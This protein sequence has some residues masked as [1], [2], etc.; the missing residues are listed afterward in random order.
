MGSI[1]REYPD[2]FLIIGGRL[3]VTGSDT[4][5]MEPIACR[6]SEQNYDIKT[7]ADISIDLSANGLNGLDIG[8]LIVSTDYYV[9]AIRSSRFV[10]PVGFMV[11]LNSTVP[12]LPEKYDRYRKVKT[13][14]TDSSGSIIETGLS[15]SIKGIVNYYADLP[16]TPADVL[17]IWIVRYGSGVYLINRKPGGLYRWDIGTTSW[18]FMAETT[19]F[20]SDA[21]FEIYN[22]ADNTKRIGFSA[23]PI[24]SGNQRF[25]IMPD[26]NVSLA[27]VNNNVRSIQALK[28]PTGFEEAEDAEI[29]FYPLTREVGVKPKSPAVDFKI[30]IRGNRFVFTTEQKVAIP[31]TNGTHFIYFN[32]LGVLVSST[33]FWDLTDTAPVAYVYWDVASQQFITKNY[34]LHGTIM[35]GITHAYLHVTRGTAYQSGLLPGDYTIGGS[36][37]LDSDAQLSIADGV[38]WDEDIVI[39]I[40]NNATPTE[41][42]EQILSPIAKIPI[43]YLSGASLWKKKTATDFPLYDNAGGALTRIGYNLDT[44]GN[45]TVPEISDNYYMAVWLFATDNINEPVIAILGQRQDSKFSDAQD[46]NNLSEIVWGD[47]PFQELKSVARLIFRSKNTM[48]NSVRATLS[49]VILLLQEIGFAS[50]SFTVTSHP[51]LSGRDLLNQHPA[52][53]IAPDVTNFD[54]NLSALDDTAQK[55]LDTLDE[56]NVPEEYYAEAEGVTV[57]TA[58][59]WQ[60]KTSLIFTPKVPGSDF[61]IEWSSEGYRN[62]TGSLEIQVIDNGSVQKAYQLEISP[63]TQWNIV[64]GIIR[65]TSLTGSQ[66]IRIQFRSTSSGKSVT[67]RRAR[68]SARKI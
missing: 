55:A 32:Y 28:E 42:F 59:T 36:G 56:L 24:S 53:S 9:Y 39:N 22:N 40:E 43:F 47:L 51:A 38:I 20:F 49:D 3:V 12:L 18:I 17:D 27:N 34:E 41:I 7:E 50:G 16:A 21:N 1:F 44:A 2:N 46:N 54:K 26:E 60:N 63:N 57:V 6:D 45:W 30:F 14:S 4:F 65:L 52:S 35:D 33:L 67:I 29:T 13:L 5:D 61:L 11:S 64:G 10:L 68:I 25:I 8:S 48:G 37:N 23:S 19:S 31:N 15:I 62:S 58:T 66:T